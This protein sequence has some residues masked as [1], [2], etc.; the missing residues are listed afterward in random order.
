M[1]KRLSQ[2]SFFAG[3]RDDS[4]TALASVQSCCSR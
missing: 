3:V 1:Y 2:E 4:A